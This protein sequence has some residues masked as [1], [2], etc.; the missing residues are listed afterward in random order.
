MHLQHTHRRANQRDAELSR[1]EQRR[2]RLRRPIRRS[3]RRRTRETKRALFFVKLL[4]I[5]SFHFSFFSPQ[6]ACTATTCANGACQWNAA[7]LA[8]FGGIIPG[9]AG[10]IWEYV[11]SSISRVFLAPC[12]CPLSGCSTATTR[13]STAK[14]YR[15][16]RL[17][18][19]SFVQHNSRSQSSFS[20]VRIDAMQRHWRQMRLVDDDLRPKVFVMYVTQLVTFFF[21]FA[22]DRSIDQSHPMKRYTNANDM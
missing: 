1:D 4:F 12:S 19:R 6:R 16:H 5:I 10:A 18:G 14:C 13:S 15:R 11:S 17:R 9:F 2:R 22:F 21:S 8:F 3:E 20:D 7:A